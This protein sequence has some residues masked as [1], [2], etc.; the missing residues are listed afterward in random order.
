MKLTSKTL[1]H[2]VKNEALFQLYS[3]LTVLLHGIRR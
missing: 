3:D 1:K 2:P